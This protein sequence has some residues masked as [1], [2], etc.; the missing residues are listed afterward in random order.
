MQYPIVIRAKSTGLYTAEPVGLSE[1]RVEAATEPAALEEVEK[2]L[3]GWLGSAAKLIHL[4]LADNERGNPW[5]ETYGRSADDPLFDAFL[6]EMA[7]ARME[8]DQE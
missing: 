8:A 4:D 1:L 5:L 2:V 6:E 7:K 3:K